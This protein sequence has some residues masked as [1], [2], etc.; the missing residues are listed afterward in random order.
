MHRKICN[1]MIIYFAI[2]SLIFTAV[3][4]SFAQ[5][6][7]PETMP[8]VPEEL[9]A[10]PVEPPEPAEKVAA[11]GL[12]TIDFK[13]ADILNV[14]RILSIKSG[15]N[16]VA[17]KDVEGTVTIRLVDVPWEKALDVVLKT[18]GFAYEREGNIVRVT[19][20]ENLDLEP[21]KT[22]VF[23]I[24]Y[25]KAEKI[26]ESIKEMITARGSIRADKRSNT[27]IVTDIPTNIYK[28]EQVINKLDE[29]TQ[30]VY[31]EARIIETTLADNEQLGIDWT[32]TATATGSIIPTTLPLH[33]SLM[34]M[35]FLD[36]RIP[37]TTT[38]TIS[39]GGAS[40]TDVVTT[41]FPGIETSEFPNAGATDFTFGTLDFSSFQAVLHMLDTRAD[42]KII[43]NPRTVTM[44]NQEATIHV[45][46][47][48]NIPLYERNESTGSMEITG[49]KTQKIGI[50]L[51]VTPHVNAQGEIVVDLHPEISSWLSYDDL[52]NVKAPVF[53]TRSAQTQVRV[54]DGET[55]V[56][57]GLIK[58]ETV[59]YVKKI[60]ILG[61]LP[62]LKYIF[63][64]R[65][66]TVNTTDLIIFVTVKLMGA[67]DLN[68]AKQ[69]E[70][71]KE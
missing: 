71:E 70:A 57:G 34:H 48:Y 47:D 61:D 11:S 66:T 69:T 50:T 4:G 62:L 31:I 49:Y 28:I 64:K 32:I 30:Q 24:S 51:T 40:T 6:M 63:S 2:I 9:S 43:S 68:L 10:E 46:E 1:I 7:A 21:L 55:I 20:V 36:N 42:T 15:V 16:I 59:E 14:L 35:P 8:E 23:S 13:D 58:E 38:P 41:G 54:R 60:P 25:A 65:N 19:T 12:V 37:V 17:G 56:I 53:A 39:G 26:A 18:Y 67:E 5:E 44:D 33:R 27:L 3:P 52:G 29:P 22:E 45:G